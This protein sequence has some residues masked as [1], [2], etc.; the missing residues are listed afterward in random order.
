[1]YITL[2]ED[3]CSSNYL[4]VSDDSSPRALVSTSSSFLRFLSPYA[5][6]ICL[7]NNLKKLE[8]NLVKKLKLDGASS[9]SGS[10]GLK[11]EVYS[12]KIIRRVDLN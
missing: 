2:S 6:K 1:M 9:I 5:C 7:I 11:H 3:V 8:D 12:L 10:P 4:S